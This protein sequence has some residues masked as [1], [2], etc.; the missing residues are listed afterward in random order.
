MKLFFTI[1]KTILL[2]IFFGLMPN[3]MVLSQNKNFKEAYFIKTN[4]DTVFGFV[5]KKN[6]NL[7]SSEVLFKKSIF[8]KAS[9]KLAPDSIKMFVIENKEFFFTKTIDGTKVFLQCLV[10][11][12]ISLYKTGLLSPGEQIP[13]SYRPA[14]FGITDDM[15]VEFYF[16]ENTT[17]QM[18][19]VHHQTFFL[20]LKEY[21]K[22]CDELIAEIQTAIDRNYSP[23]E[24]KLADYVMQ[25]NHCTHPDAQ[26]FLY[27]KPEKLKAHFG[28]TAG[29]QSTAIHFTSEKLILK[30]YAFEKKTG[31]KAGLFFEFTY[32]NKFYLNPELLI[33]SNAGDLVYNNPKA[34]DPYENMKF[35]MSTLC[36][37]V[38]VFFKYSFGKKAF[39]PF[40]KAGPE[41][42][43]ILEH[44]FKN[45]Y[46][47]S[48]PY[49]NPITF[50]IAY[51]HFG[52][53]YG[54]GLG[55]EKALG[56]DKNAMYLELRLDNVYYNL[57]GSYAT[58]T[59]GVEN[60]AKRPK[61]T[62]LARNIGLNL[63][64]KF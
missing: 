9:K 38:P 16:L 58:M 64:F 57:L 40:V 20:F 60:I 39:R 55:L 1:P 54:L 34:A 42:A 33:S 59:R 47:Y 11:G 50:G 36:L 32:N 26:A 56:T 12:Q 31:F 51:H 44:D 49:H 37:Q 5:N 46:L 61:D 25:Y 43:F 22:N 35:E 8:D 7:K 3:L 62:Y 2:I 52:L 30:D 29:L 19:V 17:G 63:G 21:F 28:L 4:N 45:Y 13:V 14:F 48:S 23:R 10:S 6:L 18:L 27:F 24:Y 41:F 53:G 15:R